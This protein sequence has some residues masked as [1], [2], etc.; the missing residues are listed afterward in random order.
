MI[1][2]LKPFHDELKVLRKDIKAETVSQIAKKSLRNTAENLAI[3]WLNEIMPQLSG[4]E[5]FSDGA[6][7]RYNSGFERLLKLSAP[8]NQKKSYLETLNEL[9]KNFRDDLI[10]PVQSGQFLSVSDSRFDELFSDIGGVVEDEYLN[11]AVQCAKLGFRRAAV[12]LGWGAA[13]DHIHRKIEEIGFSDFNVCSASM[14]SQAKGR[15]K[16]FSQTQNVMSISELRMVFDTTILWILE[17]KGLIDSNQHTRL[18]S[19]FD[20]RCHGAHPGDAPISEFNLLSFFSDLD[21][22]VFSNPRLA[23]AQNS[24]I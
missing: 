5:A 24:T 9:T 23:I 4:S 16:K 3:R 1:E 6:L 15:F 18:K 7:D 14:A 8:N 22:I 10:L 12:V 11:E 20:M 13:I 21:Q 17:G 19:C 2:T